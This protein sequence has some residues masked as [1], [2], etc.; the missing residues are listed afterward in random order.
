MS[1]ELAGGPGWEHVLAPLTVKAPVNQRAEF[2]REAPG[3]RRR[4]LLL[5]PRGVTLLPDQ[6]LQDP[7]TAMHLPHE[8]L[9]LAGLEVMQG[10]IRLS[11]TA[12]LR[13]EPRVTRATTW[14]AP[15]RSTV[16]F[17]KH[18]TEG[19]SRGSGSVHFFDQDGWM[20]RWMDRPMA[21]FLLLTVAFQLHH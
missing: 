17:R 1:A 3:A 6:V 12:L 20:D 18:G 11:G 4:W 5:P 10:P 2:A 7:W 15:G 8:A 14:S 21:F 19:K 13:I 9:Q 16:S